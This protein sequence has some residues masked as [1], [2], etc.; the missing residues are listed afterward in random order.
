MTNEL[1][2]AQK[3]LTKTICFFRSIKKDWSTQNPVSALSST[4]EMNWMSH[5]ESD[6][7]PDTCAESPAAPE[8]GRSLSPA[9]CEALLLLISVFTLHSGSS[10]LVDSGGRH[11]GGCVVFISACGSPSAVSTSWNTQASDSNQDERGKNAPKTN[12]LVWSRAF[13]ALV[14]RSV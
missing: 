2:Q 6:L 14:K 7:I 8:S 9:V 11:S 12:A 13:L 1:N 4:C 10:V 3:F 5:C